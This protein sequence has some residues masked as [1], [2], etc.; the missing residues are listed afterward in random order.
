MILLF[1]TSG[2]T[3]FANVRSAQIIPGPSAGIHV[4]AST[5]PGEKAGWFWST[6]CGNDCDGAVP[7]GDLGI[8]H[9]WGEGA[10]AKA[11]GIG[12]SGTHPYVDG[13]IQ[14]SGGRAPAGVGVRIGPPITG[15]REHQ[16]YLRKD[17]PVGDGRVL[18]LNPA[19]LLH[20]GRSPNRQNHGTFFGVVQGVGLLIPG[21]WISVTPALALVA[22][23]AEHTSYRERHGPEWRLFGVASIG[24]TIHRAGIIR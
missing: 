24:I 16:L 9:G 11:I 2:C 14:L 4:S 7:G 5:P 18:M 12:T 8:T 15:W 21:E 20:E 17:L 3:S 19:L 13:Y 6:D 23:R 22:G 10:G 1:A